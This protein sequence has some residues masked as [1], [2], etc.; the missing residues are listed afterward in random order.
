MAFLV[1]CNDNRPEGVE[2]ISPQSEDVTA[3][4]SA[5]SP[6]TAEPTA[7][8]PTP[9]PPTPTPQLAALVN[10]Q[11][12]FLADFEKELARFELAQA[13]LGIEIGGEED[14]RHLVLDALIER[15]LDSPG[16][17]RARA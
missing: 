2:I 6:P 17:S 1:A 7:L 4:T 13:E 12:I 5:L 15:E 16:G 3:E 10:G 9:I 14:Y 8:P 11:P